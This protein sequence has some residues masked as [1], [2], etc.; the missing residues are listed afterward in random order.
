VGDLQSKHWRLWR[1]FI[2]R[3]A[4]TTRHL[5]TPLGNGL[6]KLKKANAGNFSWVGWTSYTGGGTKKLQN[7]YYISGVG[8]EAEW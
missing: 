3:I 7:W 4:G 6:I 5:T 8:A 1:L 2:D